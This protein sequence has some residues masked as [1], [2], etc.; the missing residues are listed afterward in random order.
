MFESGCW[1]EQRI[2]EPSED[3]DYLQITYNDDDERLQFI[4]EFSEVF[5]KEL[6]ILVTVFD[7]RVIIPST[8]WYR[9]EWTSNFYVTLKRE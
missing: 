2:L 6:H 8:W 4:I 7:P 9:S 1:I 3:L 5:D